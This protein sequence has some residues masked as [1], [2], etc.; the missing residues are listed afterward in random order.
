MNKKIK[1]IHFMG[2]GGSGISGVASLAEKMGF[3]VSGCDLEADTA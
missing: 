2:I 1:N 3:T